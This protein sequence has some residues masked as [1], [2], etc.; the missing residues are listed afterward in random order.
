M[1]A[2]TSGYTIDCNAKDSVG[3]LSEAYIADK[4]DV[5]GVAEAAGIVSGITLATGKQF[6]KFQLVK[7]T[8]SFAIT[9]TP[10]AQNGTQFWAE[11]FTMVMNKMKSAT[12][13]IVDGLVKGT[14]VVIVKDKNGEY[15]LLGRTG[16]LDS[17][18]GD[19]GSGTASGDRNGY[20]LTFTGEEAKISHIDPTIIT[21]L[22]SPA[23]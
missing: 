19:A 2:I 15:F 1:S 8:S 11:T 5:L 6:W 13:K 23:A 17:N 20:N 7:A 9:N 21:A 14:I 4:C 12:S 10:N 18:G 22:L 3:G 16:G